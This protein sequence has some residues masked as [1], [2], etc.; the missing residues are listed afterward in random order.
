M[1]PSVLLRQGSAHGWS[2]RHNL[3]AEPDLAQLL[4][5]SKMSRNTFCDRAPWNQLFQPLVP[6]SSCCNLVFKI[7]CHKHKRAQQIPGYAHLPRGIQATDSNK[8]DLHFGSCP[9]RLLD[10]I[11]VHFVKGDVQIG[12]S[13]AGPRDHLKVPCRH[14]RLWS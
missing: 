1:K 3:V 5:L 7:I 14:R 2:D 11:H 4:K 9:R 12:Q 13:S 8:D 6:L 10:H